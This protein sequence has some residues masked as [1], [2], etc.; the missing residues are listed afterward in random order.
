MRNDT[1]SLL[2]NEELIRREKTAFLCSHQVP[3][4]LFPAIRQWAK[5]LNS[6]KD[7]VVCGCLSGI[8]RFVVKELV[9]RHIPI[10]IV[11]AEALPENVQDISRKLPGLALSEHMG[12]GRLLFASVNTD[13]ADAQV[14]GSN[15]ERRNRWM[16]SVA[17]RIVIGYALPFGR[18]QQQLIGKRNVTYLLETEKVEHPTEKQLESQGWGIYR[19]LRDNLEQ[20]SSTEAR[21]LLLD[22][23]Q[24]NTPRPSLLHSLVLAL[25]LREYERIGMKSFPAFFRL[26]GKENFR[27][28][29]WQPYLQGEETLP[30][31]AHRTIERLKV[32]SPSDLDPE[33]AVW[34]KEK[35]L[36]S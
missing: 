7:C 33:T 22:Y 1:P 28:E 10:I 21:R 4:N 29:D 17:S 16:I 23:L 14:S 26:W 3:D 18:L 35:S 12:Q 5:T 9:G 11:L 32:S 31:L 6:Q 36:N 30:P 25:V 2:G 34:M 13:S 8:E 24:L 27:S 15:A 19:Y 20:L